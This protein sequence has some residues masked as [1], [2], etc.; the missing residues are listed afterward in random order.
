MNL[1]SWN[2]F[3][4]EIEAYTITKDFGDMSFNNPDKDL[5]LKNRKQLANY[6]HTDLKHMIAPSQVHSTNFKEVSLL[7]GGKGMDTKDTALIDTDAT[8]TRDSNLFLVS[9]HADCTPVLLYCRDQGIVCAIHAGW[10]GTTKQ[11]VSKV[12]A[13]LIKAEHCHP[14]E[15]YAYIGPCISQKNF[16]VKQDVIDLVKAMDYDTSSFYYKKDPDHYLLDNKGLNKQQLLN[17]GILEKHITVS[18]YC[19]IDNNDLF[20]SHRKK[21][22]GRTI[23]IIRHKQ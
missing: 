16:E 17:H 13:H 14:Q 5:I 2:I 21:E 18:P 15:I 7:D 6:L 9:F 4:E 22:T 20:F 8:Y 10:L 3:N 23:T 1:I 19:T 12:V 11:I